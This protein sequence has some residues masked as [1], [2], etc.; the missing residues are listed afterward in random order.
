MC[1]KYLRNV[2]L[3]T[4]ESYFKKNEVEAHVLTTVLEVVA[5]E[6]S[7][8]DKWS[9]DFLMSLSKAENFDMTL[10]MAE[11]T[12][13]KLINDIVKGLTTVDK[14]LSSNVQKKYSD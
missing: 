9:G 13:K 5:H 4:L 1:Q 2:P 6:P 7:K 11:E 12:D 14:T 8:I 3:A 10:M